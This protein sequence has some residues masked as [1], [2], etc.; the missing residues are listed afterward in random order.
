M[1]VYAQVVHAPP[2]K[3]WSEVIE[4]SAWGERERVFASAEREEGQPGEVGFRVLYRAGRRVW[5]ETLTEVEPQSRVAYAVHAEPGGRNE[6]TLEFRMQ[7]IQVGTLLVLE[8]R[9]KTWFHSK[10]VQYARGF[11]HRRLLEAVKRRSQPKPKEPVAS[12]PDLDEPASP[13]K[14]GRRGKKKVDAT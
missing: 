10:L 1:P 3:V 13:T 14:P 2:A 11:W 9:G 8:V 5:K 7:P 4:R 6:V 12:P